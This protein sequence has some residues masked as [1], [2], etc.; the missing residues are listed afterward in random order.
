MF[1][2]VFRNCLHLF[3]LFFPLVII[4]RFKAIWD[5]YVISG[6]YNDF[7]EKVYD[8]TLDLIK[9]G[10]DFNKEFTERRIIDR[11]MQPEVIQPQFGKIRY[12]P[13]NKKC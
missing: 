8:L 3:Y 9:E 6:K 5:E 12:T 1:S 13:P 7:W 2:W 10:A 4:Y 11:K